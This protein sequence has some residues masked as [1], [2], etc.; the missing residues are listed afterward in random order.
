M[1][2][3]KYNSTVSTSRQESLD[4]AIELLKEDLKTEEEL[5]KG[6]VKRPGINVKKA[7]LKIVCIVLFFLL[8][9]AGAIILF[10][11]TESALYFVLSL[12]ALLIYVCFTFK[13][14]VV[15][16]VLLYQQVAS[17]NLRLSCV[18]EPSCSEYMLLAIDKYGA[19]KGVFLGIKRLLR[20]HPPN[21]G[22]DNP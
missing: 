21:G 18:F 9:V 7:V 6:S 15:T 11:K 8:G 1:D 20:C 17:A 5:R 3:D 19:F 12:A 4:K 10:V 13:K 2:T 22:I 14:L 16:L